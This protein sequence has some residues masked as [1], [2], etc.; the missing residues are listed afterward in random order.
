MK[1][2]LFSISIGTFLLYLSF[3]GVDLHS[4][5]QPLRKLNYLYLVFIII[6]IVIIYFLRSFRLKYIINTLSPNLSFIQSLSYNCVGYFFILLLPMRLGELIIPYLIK[7]DGF[8]S[9][10]SALSMIAVE[11]LIDLIVLVSLLFFIVF[12]YVMPDWLLKSG[13]FLSGILL[14]GCIFFIIMYKHSHYA[15][16]L[17]LPIMNLFPEPLHLKIKNILK[18]FKEG[19][20]IFS[21]PVRV[22]F[23]VFISYVVWFLSAT[24]VYFI[25]K[26]INL[27]LDYLTAI[28]VMVINVIGV[29]IPAGPAMIG[30]FQ[31]SII[32]ALG[33]FGVDKNIAFSIANVYYII[34]FSMTILLGLP[35]FHYVN[36]RLSEIKSLYKEEKNESSYIS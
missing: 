18:G 12:N 13:V 14:L 5:F 35:F 34:S 21:S 30:N 27:D 9:I 6:T 28:S 11:R 33:L 3:K 29:S 24:C 20:S 4:V 17:L 19:F 1:K 25:F 22:T 15:W 32:V 16:K 23:T 31:Y 8:L 7:K 10:S 2:I 36:F 26:F